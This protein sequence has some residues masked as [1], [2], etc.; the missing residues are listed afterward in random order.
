MSNPDSK[1]VLHYIGR[2]RA[3]H[4]NVGRNRY[5]FLPAGGFAAAVLETDAPTLLKTGLYMPAGTQAAKAAE[6][7][8]KRILGLSA[9]PDTGDTPDTAPKADEV[10]APKVKAGKAR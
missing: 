6:A 9:T 7:R 1:I 3:V 5:H 4:T 8:A 10:P 2:E